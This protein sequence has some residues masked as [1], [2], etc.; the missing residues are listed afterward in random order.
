MWSRIQKLLLNK[1]D[2]RERHY[3]SEVWAT[4]S[5][6]GER[7]SSDI[8]YKNLIAERRNYMHCVLSYIILIQYWNLHNRKEE[9]YALIVVFVLFGV[10]I[11]GIVSILF[12]GE[13]MVWFNVG[14]T[15]GCP[16]DLLHFD[17]FAGILVHKSVW[18]DIDWYLLIIQCPQPAP[19]RQSLSMGNISLGCLAPSTPMASTTIQL[20]S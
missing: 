3:S 9:F 13:L 1:S 16:A 19:T 8:Q 20:E 18:A 17:C 14:S 4:V 15:M 7:V 12:P 2:R 6:A 10:P 11:I 5:W